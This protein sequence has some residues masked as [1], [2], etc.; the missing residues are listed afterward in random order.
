MARETL[1]IRV[2]EDLA[3]LVW[4]VCTQSASFIADAMVLTCATD[5]DPD[6]AEQVRRQLPTRHVT[7]DGDAI[8]IWPRPKESQ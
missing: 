4:P 2:P 5:F 1:A 6:H 7:W 8:T 3:G